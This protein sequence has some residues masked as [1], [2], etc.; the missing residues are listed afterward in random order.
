[1][2]DMTQVSVAPRVRGG[3][4]I[5]THLLPASVIEAARGERFGM[6]L[7]EKA[8]SVPGFNLSLVPMGNATSLL[9]RLDADALDGAIVSVPPPLFRADLDAE[10]RLAYC[11]LL[12]DGLLETI[13]A[14]P[15]RLLALAY[16]PTDQPDVALSVVRSLGRDWAGVIIGT[17]L[18]EGSYADPIHHE[19]WAALE[20]AGLPVLLHPSESRDA[21]LKPY[22]LSNLLGNPFETALAAAS[23][24]FGDVPGRFPRLQMI[25]SHGGSAAVTLAGRWQK[26]ITSGRSGVTTLK[27][28]P[29]EALQ[30]FNVDSIVHS[31]ETLKA[32]VALVGPDRLLLGSDWPF[33][34]GTNS[35]EDDLGS[36]EPGVVRAA[37]IDNPRRVFG[38]S[39]QRP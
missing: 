20:D 3:W 11:Q 27:L 22:Y 23:L 33:P 4:D 39:L 6:S 1:M 26:G 34:M 18:G 37:R 29:L 31:A 19:L 14:S 13:A 32:I 16:V 30:W 25:L 28:S 36:L 5:H 9:A 17:E 35:A 10:A 7:G 21:R 12:N 15:A 38:K 2:I 24:I 8:V